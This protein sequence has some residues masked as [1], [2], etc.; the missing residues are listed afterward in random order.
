MHH[1]HHSMMTPESLSKAE[2]K[3][4]RLQL[5]D[6]E[7]AL[8]QNRQPQP[9]MSIHYRPDSEKLVF[10]ELVM[11]ELILRDIPPLESHTIKLD[12]LRK[13]ARVEA[14]IRLLLTELKHGTPS[15]GACFYLYKPSRAS[16]TWRITLALRSSRCF[17]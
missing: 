16:C 10:G 9:H 1:H 11:V 3:D 5:D 6:V 7:E 15:Q 12:T 2:V 14:K 8:Y 4:S 17:S 13:A